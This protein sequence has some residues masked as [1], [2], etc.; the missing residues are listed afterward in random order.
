MMLG[1]LRRYIPINKTTNLYRLFILPAFFWLGISPCLAQKYSFSHYDIEDGLIQSQVNKVSLDNQHRLWLATYGGACR[2]DGKEYTPYTRQNGMPTNFVYTVLADRDGSTWFGTQTGLVHLVDNKLVSYPIPVIMMKSKLVTDI[3][4]DG[5]GKIWIALSNHLFSVEGNKLK[6]QFVQDTIKGLATTLAVNK[7]GELF[8]SL[9]RKGIYQ[10]S[11]SKWVNIAALPDKSIAIGHIVFD[12][13]DQ[14]RVYLLC[15]NGLYT[16]KN[17]NVTPYASSLIAAIKVPLWCLEQDSSSNLWIGTPNGAYCIKDQR[18]LHFEANNGFT[19]NPITEIYNDADN[20]LWFGSQGSGLYKYEGDRFVTFDRSH[21][22]SGSEVIMGISKDAS[23]DFLFGLSGGGLLRYEGMKLSSVPIPAQYPELNRIGCVFTDKKGV[24]W[25]GTE[26]AGVWTYQNNTFKRITG[27]GIYS[28]N[29]IMEDEHGTIWFVTPSGCFYLQDNKPVRI[30]NI[31]TFCSAIIPLGRDSVVVGTQDGIVMV[32]NK[33]V[34]KSFRI[35]ELHS[36]TI[37]CMMQYKNI[38]IIGTDDR[39]LFTWNRQNGEVKNYNLKDGLNSNAIYGVVADD[40][41]VIWL[42]T[43]RGVNRML[44]DSKKSNLLVAGNIGL[45]LPILESNQN[46]ILYSDHKVWI[47]T[48]KGL[49]ACDVDDSPTDTSTPHITIQSVKLIPQNTGNGT[50]ASTLLT[51]GASLPYN[52]NHLSIA[53]LGIYLKDPESV[54]YRYKL[55]G[56]DSTYSLP[57]NNDMVDYPSLPPGKYTFEVKAFTTNGMLSKNTASFSFS[58]T[59]PFYQTIPFRVLAVTFFIVLGIILQSYRH[60]LRIKRLQVIEATK[61][62]ES[63]RIRQQTAEDFHD[64]LGNKLTRITVLSEILDTKM[65]QTQCDQKKLLEQIK[66]NASSLYNGTKDILWALDPQSDNLYEI[67]SHIKDFGNE[68]F[69]DT[70]VEFEFNG[71]EKSLDQVKLPMEYS[72][73]IPMIFKELL[74]NILK[75]AHATHVVLNVDS[76]QKEELRLTL[77][78]N[79]MG[80]DKNETRKGQGI[81]NIVMRIKRINGDININS[82]RGKGTQIGLKIK[83]NPLV[84]H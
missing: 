23:N 77:T 4:Q 60:N 54:F 35:N 20:N 22:M 24:T 1:I 28:V 17:G 19:D 70:P 57:V 52:Q 56:L 33:K 13:N 80:F 53:F 10:L 39:G 62:E 46:A 41:G 26:R 72:R 48:T 29:G 45:K 42:G 74:N 59:P 73:N 5:A 38:L 58:I 36:S 18:L 84:T 76:I 11:G 44:F 9:Y 8:V 81:N 61:R 51:D 64:E 14:G 31:S 82:E 68:L 66:Q 49:V 75:H 50:P 34:D 47:G 65:D 30:E 37:F 63:L 27:E 69:L 32:V 21:G 83:I 7:K 79:G 43:G 15:N 71:I 67:L 16:A 12:R 2:F 55:K 3:V 25:L 78:D 40:K 6:E